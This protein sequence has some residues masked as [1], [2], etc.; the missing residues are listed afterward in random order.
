MHIKKL[1]KNL[2]CFAFRKNKV[3]AI[4]GGG[5]VRKLQTCFKS[6]ATIMYELF[7]AFPYGKLK[8]QV[9]LL[10]NID[11]LAR[12]EFKVSILAK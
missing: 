8:Q 5:V 9:K 6:S 11:I 2:I 4:L 1:L 12:T 10:K 3:F 7:Y